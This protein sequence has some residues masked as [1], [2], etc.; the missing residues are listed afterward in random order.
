[1]P[2]QASPEISVP[3]PHN[4]RT[5][6]EDEINRRRARAQTEEFRISNADPRHPIFS[7]FRVRSG[8]LPLAA[9]SAALLM[10]I[11]SVRVPDV[12]GSSRLSATPGCGIVTSRSTPGSNLEHAL[13]S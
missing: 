6:D 11:S 5:T 7:N 1:M 2:K 9:L 13:P 8:S 4:W 12:W 3:S 10:V